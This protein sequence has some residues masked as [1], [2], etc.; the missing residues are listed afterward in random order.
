VYAPDLPGYGESP[1]LSGVTDPEHMAALML[2]FADAL[3]LERF[4]LNGH[5]FSAGVTVYMSFQYPERVRRLVMTCPSTYRSERERRMVGYIHRLTGVWMAMR[6]PW[7]IDVRTIYRL[8][9]RPFFYR[10]PID[11]VMLQESFGDFLRMDQ[12]TALQSAINAVSPHY[13]EVLQQVTTPAMVVGARQDRIMPGY[14]PPLVAS[15]LQ[16]GHVQWVERCGHLP[17]VERP[18]I[19]NRL[20]REFLL[21][22]D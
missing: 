3:G 9:S 12:E 21:H 7:M 2:E 19:Y 15:I 8:V 4:D 22:D 13:N 10:V 20:L 1:P 14:G 11:N 16:H 17:M 5:S 6:R 18:E